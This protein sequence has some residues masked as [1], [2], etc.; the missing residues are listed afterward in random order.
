M[1]FVRQTRMGAGADEVRAYRQPQDRQGAR[2]RRA[3]LDAWTRRQGDRI[4]M[5]FVAVHEFVCSTKRTSRPRSDDVCSQGKTGSD[6]RIV[7]PTRL[8]Q[9]RSAAQNEPQCTISLDTLS[10]LDGLSICSDRICRALTTTM[11]PATVTATT[12]PRYRDKLARGALDE[13]RFLDIC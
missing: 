2:S 10:R 6:R 13:R 1:A 7:K 3:A 9:L 5:P 11:S 12:T 4:E 8:T